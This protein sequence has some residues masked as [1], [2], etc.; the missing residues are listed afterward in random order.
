[1]STNSPAETIHMSCLPFH[2]TGEY[3][4]GL[5]CH[6]LSLYQLVTND[7]VDVQTD[8]STYWPSS[9]SSCNIGE[10][11]NGCNMSYFSNQERV[12]EMILKLHAQLDPLPGRKQSFYKTVCH[13]FL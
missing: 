13:V 5:L 2:R 7:H 8:T 3:L 1:M 11:R 4:T 6:T 9:I 10:S 12:R